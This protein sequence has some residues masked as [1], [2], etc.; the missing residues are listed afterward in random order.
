MM[1]N[2]KIYF[3]NTRVRNAKTVNISV[4][5]TKP[6]IRFDRNQ[7]DLYTIIMVDPDA[8]YPNDPK[9]KYF[10]HWF[11]VNNT[12]EL[13]NYT[14][15]NPPSDSDNHRYCVFVYKQ[16]AKIYPDMFYSLGRKN[17]NLMKFE[18]LFYVT[19]IASGY[20]ITGYK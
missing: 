7:D 13:M 17:F 5:Q 6:N 14:P 2:L 12:E 15:P 4:T 20:F 10:L 16:E 3:N 11:V 19:K 8:P 18:E 1:Q 9:F